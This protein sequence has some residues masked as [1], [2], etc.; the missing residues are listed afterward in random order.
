MMENLSEGGAIPSRIERVFKIL[1][2]IIL[3]YI[4]CFGASSV[5]LASGQDCVR[6]S[7]GKMFCSEPPDTN[8]SDLDLNERNKNTIKVRA[9]D[10]NQS[11]FQ[12]N[13]RNPITIEPHPTTM[14]PKEEIEDTLD[15]TLFLT[16]CSNTMKNTKVWN[17]N[18]W[19]Q[20]DHP[21]D[22]C[23]LHATALAAKVFDFDVPTSKCMIINETGDKTRSLERVANMYS[24]M[25]EDTKE[26][27]IEDNLGQVGNSAAIEVRKLLDPRN[28]TPEAELARERFKH[29]FKIMQINR[30]PDYKTGSPK[31]FHPLM[32]LAF[33]II[34]FSMVIPKLVVTDPSG[35]ITNFSRTLSGPSK[36]SFDQ[37]VVPNE[38]KYDSL[39]FITSSSK[40]MNAP[41]TTRETYLMIYANKYNGGGTKKY[42]KDINQCVSDVGPVYKKAKLALDTLYRVSDGRSYKKEPTAFHLRNQYTQKSPK[43]QDNFGITD[44]ADGFVQ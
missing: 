8:T 35:R 12:L 23:I 39:D 37:G 13:K 32:S 28:K 19:N 29:F 11:G 40:K 27:K 3:I 42:A 33:S 22:N 34:Y 7:T 2:S 5:T 6:L 25:D 9:L 24:F 41:L 26:I 17:K 30:I 15:Y 38:L 14:E 10:G 16:A 21:G 43:L 20:Q 36:I 4:V 31:Q 18:R 44:D 1:F